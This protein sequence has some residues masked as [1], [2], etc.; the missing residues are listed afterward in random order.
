M[1]S[2]QWVCEA[3]DVPVDVSL[4]F[5][6]TLIPWRQEIETSTLTKVNKAQSTS[7]KQSDVF[8][9]SSFVFLEISAL[10]CRPSKLNHLNYSQTLAVKC[11]KDTKVNNPKRIILITRLLA[12]VAE[13]FTCNHLDSL[14]EIKSRKEFLRLRQ[15]ER[16]SFTLS[17]SFRF[18]L[19][20]H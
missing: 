19:N 11:F 12:S 10:L 4:R 14:S 13:T 15:F 20:S 8:L 5:L 18:F 1:S 2:I 7:L 17:M 3:W 9:V 6:S 16:I